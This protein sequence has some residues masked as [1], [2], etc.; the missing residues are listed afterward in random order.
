[1]KNVIQAK[2]FKVE[3]LDGFN[4]HHEAR[5]TVNS[6]VP[7]FLREARWIEGSVELQLPP[8]R[9]PDRSR[10]SNAKTIN[11]DGIYYRKLTEVIKVA[12]SDETARSFHFTPFRMLH[13]KSGESESERVYSEAYNS[14]AFINEDEKVQSLPQEEGCHRK[15]AVAALMLYS[16]ATRLASFGE[17][18]LWPIYCYFGN[19]SK[20]SCSKPSDHAAHY[21]AYIP[22]VSLVF[23]F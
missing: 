18:S 6:Q 5:H 4:A 10:E 3:H 9:K 16:D 17:A 22:S 20:Y 8:E 1:V 11:V 23:F 7:E 21:I 14:D 19:Q 15:K 13:K 2:D 12:F